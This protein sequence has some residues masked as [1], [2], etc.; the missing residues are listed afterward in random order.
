MRMN[1]E[2]RRD[3]RIS[4]RITPLKWEFFWKEKNTLD[5]VEKY[6]INLNEAA[7]LIHPMMSHLIIPYISFQP[8]ISQLYRFSSESHVQRNVT[9][10]TSAGSRFPREVSMGAFPDSVAMPS[11]P[12]GCLWFDPSASHKSNRTSG[13]LQTTEGCTALRCGGTATLHRHGAGSADR[14]HQYGRTQNAPN[15]HLGAEISLSG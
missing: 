12:P 6:S 8:D 15:K 1:W 10:E 11:L 5:K 14:A 2:V 9:Q 13:C 4:Y 7:F 3:L